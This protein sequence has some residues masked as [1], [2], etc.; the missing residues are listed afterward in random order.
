[1]AKLAS[2]K[3][4]IALALKKTGMYSPYL[5]MQIDNLASALQTL[6]MCNKI[7]NS[8]EFEPFIEKPTREGPQM[9]EHPVFKVEERTRNSIDRQM[10]QLKLTVEDIIGHPDVPD[11]LDDIL[12]NMEKIK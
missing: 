9:V 11:A 4:R 2:H 8:P 12:D 6:D 3:K 7:K 5:T 10:R 1:M